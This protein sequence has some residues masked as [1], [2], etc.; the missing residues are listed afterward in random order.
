M[1]ENKLNIKS[2]MTDFIIQVKSS[3][4]KKSLSLQSY[5]VML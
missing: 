4:K 5:Q 1:L 3:T 2:K